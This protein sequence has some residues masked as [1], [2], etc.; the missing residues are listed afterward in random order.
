MRREIIFTEDA[1]Q[2]I[3]AYSQA[4]RHGNTLYISGQIPLDPATQEL[5]D[6]DFD[7]QVERVFANLAAVAEAGGTRLEHTLK[8]GIYLVDMNDFAAVNKAMQR[9]FAEPFP[10]RAAVGVA[11][12]PK[13]ARV[14]ADA[15]VA[16]D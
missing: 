1:P 16:V 6:G 9:V 5:V 3:G 14:E 12:L 10:A 2:A 4:V 13:G 15:I 11:S 8:L 7:A